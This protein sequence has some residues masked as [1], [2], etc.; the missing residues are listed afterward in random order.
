MVS[1]IRKIKA[2]F[3]F[4]HPNHELAVFGLLQ[5][6]SPSILYLTDGG[7][8]DRIEQTKSGLSYIGLLDQA[9]FLNHTETAFYD[10]LL[11]CDEG[12]Y[13]RV[14]GQLEQWLR[15]VQPERVFCDAVEFYNP[16]HDM[17]LP[18]VLAASGKDAP[19][20][21]FEIPLIYQI[22]SADEVFSIQRMPNPRTS[23]Q[24]EVVLS[25]AELSK[26]VHARH[27]IYLALSKQMGDVLSSVT[28]EHARREIVAR[29]KLELD[30][31]G[32]GRFLRYEARAELLLS[33]NVIRGPIRYRESYQ[34]LVSRLLSGGCG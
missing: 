20:D 21:V 29:A 1:K 15:A 2:A 13:R 7:A 6:L 16:V 24:L 30:Q 12:F 3:V 4:S 34:P 11:E 25:D 17:A 18:L 19:W 32:D 8:G 33:Q 26:K 22:T 27:H 14:L 28:P 5:Q 9:N 10:A 31:L 23:D